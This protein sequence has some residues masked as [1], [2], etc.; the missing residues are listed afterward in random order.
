M[1]LQEL[2]KDLYKENGELVTGRTHEQ[3]QYDPSISMQQTASPF[4]KEESWNKPQ[5]GLSPKGKK[6]LWI[7]IAVFLLIALI[8]GGFLGYKWWLKNAFHQ[9]RVV[10]S[11]EGPKEADSTQLTKYIIHY[12]NENRVTLKNAEI[13]LSYAENFQPT[14]NLNLKSLGPT[15]SKFFI[16]DIKPM[17]EG[18]VELKGIFYAPK[19]FPVYLR[20]SLDFTP[21]NG[22]KVL[23]ME[24]QIGVNITAAP[25][26]LSAS[27]PN[28]ASDGDSV[29]Y[30]IDYK[31]LDIRQMNNI[32]IKIDFP[33]GFEFKEAVPTASEKNSIW[34]LGNLESYQAGKITIKGKLKGNEGEAKDV[35]ISLGH[36][37]N[38]GKFIAYSKQ[39][40]S[41]HM[42]M[43]VLAIRQYLDGKTDGIV[44]AGE[45]LK[46]VV[47][48][49]NTGSLGLRDAIVTAK[50]E[51]KMLDFSKIDVE[52]GSY[53]GETN[54]ITWKASDVP[55]LS[56]INPKGGG[57]VRFFLPIKSIIPIENKLDKNFVI[58]SEAK[59][60]SPDIPTPV[61]SN[62][63]IGT[64][65]LEL[66]LASKVLFDTKAYYNDLVVKNTGPIPM[67]TGQETTFSVHWLVSTV[68]NDIKGGRVVS[69]LPSGIRWVGKV[70]PE[71]EKISYNPRSNQIIWEVG[72]VESGRGI[73]DRPREVI[74]QVGVKPQVNQ[75]GQHVILLNKSSFSATDD[76]VLREIALEGEKKDTQLYED[77]TVGS[78][79]GKV[80]K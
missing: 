5:K 10:V 6:V 27:A 31:N 33:S 28:N 17:S 53:N 18:T 72:D 36:V 39:E 37:G 40:L 47:E 41:T 73:L 45:V 23:S 67:I 30:V 21:S 14:D 63:I 16:G 68:S 60:D 59:I 44:S 29:V 24:N 15:A 77:P 42:V 51:G 56:I 12:K 11:F 43:P 38:D 76:F 54:T 34:Y 64:S 48:F 70:I 20:A 58:V 66:K 69:S 32:Q 79:N 62:K 46:Y 7:S 71:G 65:Q 57:Q 25:V 35:V 9:D 2:N 78:T 74:F 80:A 1:S 3:S 75:V 26:L 55:A 50:V 49:K 4:D 19:D 8:P 61:D 13:K 52:G 22:G